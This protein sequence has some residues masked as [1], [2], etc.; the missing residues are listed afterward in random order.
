VDAT[1]HDFINLSSASREAL[2]SANILKTLPTNAY[3]YGPEATGKKTLA[4]YIVPNAPVVDGRDFDKLLGL[5]T[6]HDALIVTNFDHI[7]N[8]SVLKN[9][10]NQHR[11]RIVATSHEKLSE[12]TE[13]LFFSITIYL[14]SF[15]ERLEDVYGLA[16]NYLS[17]AQE[18]FGGDIVEEIDYSR[19]DLTQN[20]TSIKR[21]VFI[22]YLLETVSDQQIMELLESFFEFKLGG[23]NDY[24]DFLYLFEAPLI[25]VGMKQYG[26]QSKLADVL[27]LNRNTL[28]KKIADNEHYLKEV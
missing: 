25:N 13:D 26:S 23:K 28:R 7:P 21:S 18:T 22:Q 9:A 19:V 17:L 2:K 3:I 14:P 8:T 6:I 16:N 12:A 20:A 10:L 15:S 27:G 5:L 24:R 1:N 11:T 4:N